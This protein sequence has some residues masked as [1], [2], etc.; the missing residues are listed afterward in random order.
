MAKVLQKTKGLLLYTTH[1]QQSANK[2]CLK[3]EKTFWKIISLVCSMLG[4]VFFNFIFIKFV[5]RKYINSIQSGLNCLGIEIFVEATTLQ[6]FC[7]KIQLLYI[8]C[9]AF[10]FSVLQVQCTVLRL[11]PKA[12]ELIIK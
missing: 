9:F 12:C 11:W 6:H 7:N 4:V 1:N 10:G 5:S 8:L 3:V 2:I